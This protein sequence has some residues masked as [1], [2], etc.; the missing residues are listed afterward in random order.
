MILNASQ[1]EAL[2]T[3]A[4]FNLSWGFFGKELDQPVRYK[5]LDELDTD[6]LENIIISCGNTLPP[7]YLASILML[8]KKRYSN[9]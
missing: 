5:T 2:K 3:Q 1:C 9:E 6:H 8:L 7:K 4:D